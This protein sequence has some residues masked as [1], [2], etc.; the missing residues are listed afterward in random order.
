MKAAGDSNLKR[1]TL[2]LG[3]KSPAIFLDDVDS[4]FIIC[5]FVR[6]CQRGLPLIFVLLTS[7]SMMNLIFLKM[8]FL[9]FLEQSRQW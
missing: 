8:A 1:T 4:E 3:G 9:C 2:E 5:S 6:S 7:V